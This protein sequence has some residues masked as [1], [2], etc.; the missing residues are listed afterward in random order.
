M[1]LAWFGRS[2]GPNYL[3]LILLTISFAGLGL[4]YYRKPR[5]TMIIATRIHGSTEY[6]T[7]SKVVSLTPQEP[8][9]ADQN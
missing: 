6:K 7:T 8:S 9:I 3:L 4:L 2:L 1:L 5:R